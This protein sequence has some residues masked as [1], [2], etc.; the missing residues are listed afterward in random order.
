MAT[1]QQLVDRARLPLQ[2]DAK[3]RYTDATLLAY[4]DAAIQELILKRNDLFP[5][6]LN[7]PGPLG[8]GDTF[9]LEYTH[10]QA[11]AD[12]VTAR[13]RAKS[14]EEVTRA[15]TKLHFDLFSFGALK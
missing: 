1:M 6:K 8:L 5:D 3:V 4:G 12:Y 7:L 15:Q 9:P 10:F 11:I 13:A 2:D 14:G